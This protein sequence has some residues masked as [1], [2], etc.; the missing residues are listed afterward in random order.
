MG[1][2]DNVYLINNE[3]SNIIDIPRINKNYVPDG[4]ICIDRTTC[5]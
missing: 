3:A 5:S 2:L 4:T 1:L